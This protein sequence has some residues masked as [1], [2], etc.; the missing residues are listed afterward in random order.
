MKRIVRMVAGVLLVVL[1]VLGLFLPFLQGILFL[2]VGLLLL[3]ADIRPIRRC[4][5]GQMRRHPKRYRLFRKAHRWLH[6]RKRRRSPT[7]G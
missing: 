6:G 4:V 3:S 5:L 1:G 2:G 7:G